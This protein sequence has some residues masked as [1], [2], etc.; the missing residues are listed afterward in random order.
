MEFLRMTLSAAV[1]SLYL[2]TQNAI[3]D[4][5]RIGAGAAPTE[6]VLK[7]VK[8]A[9]EA[10]TGIKLLIIS[11]GPKNA[12]NDLERGVVDA[13]SAGLSFDDWLALMKKENSEVKDPTSLDPVIIGKDRIV[14]LVDKT[15]QVKSLSKEQ[16]QAIFSG[17][18]SS[19]KEFDGADVPILV[20]WG[21]LIPG[22]NSMFEKNIMGGKAVTKDVLEA[23][24]AE[25]VRQNVMSNPGAVGIGPAAIL[26]GSV[27]S[28]STP[29]VARVIT[30]LTKGKPA[31]KVQ[32]LIDFIKG[33]GQKYVK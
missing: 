14:V 7:P 22:T 27:N 29:E 13:A 17:Q 8:D 28:P 11:S 9:F 24:T 3:A 33:E 15:N 2:L 1:I 25:D 6:N 4:E 30:L 21:K 26:D 10:K 32:K 18:A 5:L 16:L 19:W 23:T 20:V 12:L 31:D